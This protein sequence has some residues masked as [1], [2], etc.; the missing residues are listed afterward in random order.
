MG[1]LERRENVPD[2]GGRQSMDA[3]RETR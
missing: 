1:A 3:V 2:R